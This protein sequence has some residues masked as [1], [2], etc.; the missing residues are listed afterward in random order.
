MPT[1][2]P[3]TI[4]ITCSACNNA[5]LHPAP[6]KPKEHEHPVGAYVSSDTCGP[7]KPTST[8]GNNHMLL[9]VCA[10]SKFVL[11][12]FIKDRKNIPDCIHT[13]IT[14]IIN[15]MKHPLRDLRS[16]NAKE[17]TSQAMKAMYAKYGLTLHLRTPHQPQEN[18][19]AERLNRTIMESVRALLHTAGLSD[20]YWEDAARDT[21]FKYNLM[22]HATINTSP[23]QLWYNAKPILNRIFTFGQL[24]TIPIYAPKKKLEPR[25]D[26]ARY[27]YAVSLTHVMT[28]NLRTGSYQPVRAVDFHPYHKHTDPTTATATAFK[29]KTEYK[30][31]PPTEI[32]IHTPPPTNLA[33]ARQYPDA[34]QWETAHN[35]ELNN[36]DAHHSIEWLPSEFQ[37][38]P[39][40]VIP[41]MMIYR[42]KRSAEGNILQRKA[43]C[44][45]RGDLM[46]PGLHYNP[47]HTTTYTADRTTQ[48][49][50][51]A[52]HATTNYPL[53]HFDI[54]SA[55]LHEQYQHT[56]PIYVKQMPLF[57][58]SHKHQGKYGRLIGNLYGSPPA[59]YYYNFGLQNYL[60][61]IGYTRSEH[62]PCLYTKHTPTGN[63][64]ISTTI[65]DFLVL[66]THQNL[67]DE[68]Y[69][70]LLQ[71]YKIKRLGKPTR[72][73][74]W[75]LTRTKEGLHLSQPDAV[76][77]ILQQ[78]NMHDSNPTLS[79][80]NN[81]KPLDHQQPTEPLSAREATR[82]RQILGEIR[83]I[84]DSTR[85]D[86]AYATNRLAQHMSKPQRHHQ[87]ALKTL[88]RYLKGTR[89][90]GLLYPHKPQ[91][92]QQPHPLNVFS[93]ADFA[94]NRKSITGTVHCF[95]ATPISWQ[96]RKQSVV[97]LFTTEAE[98]ISATDATRHT[99]WL[100]K[101]LNDINMTP[102]DPKP[103]HIDN[104]SAILIAS[105]KAPTKQRKYIDIRHHYLQHHAASNTIDLN[106]IPTDR[107][108][109]DI[110]TKPLHRERFQELRK[111]LSITT[112]PEQK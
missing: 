74:N 33:Q 82:Y 39:K 11:A 59:A 98:Y 15:R 87:Q 69:H 61:S 21:I 111:A 84:T 10:A 8:H 75:T 79:P 36:L 34:K 71:K 108:L 54:K 78:T 56:N 97:S 64:L 67:V 20:K 9:V 19:I 50:L 49:L 66:A 62:D 22:H 73:L 86:I 60:S 102:S 103:H 53:E 77:A 91:T 100:R 99:T 92:E 27:M 107:M 3:S 7:I 52:I 109:A 94:N 68:L 47:E 76:D 30:R 16:D 42:Y 90:H 32:E 4:N 40:S 44:N 110:F 63:T 106:R 18:E 46:K 24:G 48:R 29:T 55:Y 17:Y 80:Y 35:T 1:Q 23:Y 89:T 2:L 88:L 57:D 26:P 43:R 81:V 51:I 85:P 96:S 13:S 65:D 6:H 95:H 25:A 38:P 72:F 37:P 112:R 41:L 14:H 101:L 104:Q 70:L 58:G 12:H 83:Y 31:Q 93:D 28:L 105:S 5:K 45:L